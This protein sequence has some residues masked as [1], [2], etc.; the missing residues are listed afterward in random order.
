MHDQ[1]KN[2]KFRKR[3]FIQCVK[4][5][6]KNF[7]L[8]PDNVIHALLK[9]HSGSSAK[10]LNPLNLPKI[11]PIKDFWFILKAKVT[12]NNW[13][14]KNIDQLNKKLKKKNS[15]TCVPSTIFIFIF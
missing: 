2:R 8:R 4:H 7:R 15:V 13:S 12:K 3:E 10:N 14:A 9:E 1:K 6:L 11:N 5:G